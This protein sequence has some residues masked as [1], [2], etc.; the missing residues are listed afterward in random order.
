MLSPSRA[1][2]PIK[3][4]IGTQLLIQLKVLIAV[5]IGALLLFGLYGLFS[6][7][8]IPTTTSKVD[9]LF[10]L[11]GHFDGSSGGGGTGGGDTPVTPT[12]EI[13]RESGS[14]IPDGAKYTKTDGTTLDGDGTNTMPDAPAA[15]D[16]YEEG[17][18]IYTY[19]GIYSDSNVIGWSVSTSGPYKDNGYGPILS[20]IANEPVLSIWNLFYRN[21]GLNEAPEIPSSVIDM[22]AA[23]SETGIS[24]AP[25]IPDG[26]IYMSDAFNE[27]GALKTYVGSTDVD[28]DFSHYQIPNSVTDLSGAF[29][30]CW[31]I[32]KAPEIPNSVISISWSFSG[33]SITTA[34]EIPSSVA[35]MSF[36]FRDCEELSSVPIIPSSVTNMSYAFYG[37][38]SLVTAPEIPNSVTNMQ[39]A[40]YGCTSLATAP[41]IPS[42]VTNMYNTFEG[43]TL[44][45][46]Q[47]IT[48]PSSVTLP[49]GTRGFWGDNGPSWV[50]Q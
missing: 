6:D 31:K 5:V 38:T 8:V 26:M 46:G 3:W 43:C 7:V 14:V 17:D 4:I 23:F 39:S 24:V 49:S 28:G 16:T 42:S 25:K 48:I 21:H 35:D 41:E 18:Y 30:G 50:K 2:H 27:C 1:M 10:K 40:F 19:G 20:E 47:T 37:C 29:S 22:Y 36:A 11:E 15:N 45:K 12:P 33:T 34:P 32:K 13:K 9:S 44:L